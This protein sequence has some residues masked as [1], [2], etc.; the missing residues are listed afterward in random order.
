MSKL[1]NYEIDAITSKVL[2]LIKEENKKNQPVFTKETE[3][4]M[5]LKNKLNKAEEEIRV[6]KAKM[7]KMDNEMKVKYDNQD[8]H[9]S[10]TEYIVHDNSW[11]NTIPVRQE[12]ILSQIKSDNLDEIIEK[13]V[14]QFVR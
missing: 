1:K 13:I 3:E 5:K 12:I 11:R 8:I 10:D 6:L 2:A 4:R 9:F 14:K 7:Y